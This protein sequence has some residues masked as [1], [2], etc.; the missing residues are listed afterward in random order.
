MIQHT[1]LCAKFKM[2]L[3]TKVDCDVT[4]AISFN[5]AD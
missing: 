3:F 4:D 1:E 2:L 5:K